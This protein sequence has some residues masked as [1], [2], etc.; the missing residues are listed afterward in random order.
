MDLHEGSGGPGPVPSAPAA[1]VSV[2]APAPAED[3]SCL[4]NQC[5]KAPACALTFPECVRGHLP[6][7][8]RPE[9]SKEM[10]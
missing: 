7:A 1:V 3:V 4:C 5:E 10:T 9:R 6:P 8:R 2:E